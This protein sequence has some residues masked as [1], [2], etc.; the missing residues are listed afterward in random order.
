MIGGV[1]TFA[2]AGFARV[3]AFV[4]WDAHGFTRKRAHSLILPTQK[5]YLHY[6]GETAADPKKTKQN[7]DE[8][9]LENFPA[10]GAEQG[11][12][13]HPS[14]TFL[15]D[16]GSFSM[17]QGI[18]WEGRPCPPPC[19]LDNQCWCGRA[20]VTRVPPPPPSPRAKTRQIWGWVK[21]P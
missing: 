9:S 14:S 17:N 16:K 6:G 4:T 7:G 15:G 11:A 8:H 13:A 21:G 19:A 18:G 12:G 20:G 10:R 5:I 2:P 3:C 1:R